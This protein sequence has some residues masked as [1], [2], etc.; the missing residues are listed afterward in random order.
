MLSDESLEYSS[1][2]EKYIYNPCTCC[3]CK[4]F[5]SGD[6][7]CYFCLLEI[8]YEGQTL[9]SVNNGEA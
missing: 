7:H 1:A 6:T 2:S 9:C 4:A 8:E 5:K 3:W